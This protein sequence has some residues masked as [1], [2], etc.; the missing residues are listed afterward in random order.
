MGLEQLKKAIKVE[1]MFN[2]IRYVSIDTNHNGLN[3]VYD[4]DGNSVSKCRLS[5]MLE[6]GFYKQIN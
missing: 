1:N 5:Q 4:V 2:I 3:I 6:T